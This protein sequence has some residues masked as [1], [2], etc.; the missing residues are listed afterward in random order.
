MDTRCA[1]TH[2]NPTHIICP[3]HSIQPISYALRIL[4]ITISVQR[5]A[6]DGSVEVLAFLLD[7]YPESASI[8]AADGW[9]NLLHLAIAD[10]TNESLAKT[11]LLCSR[12]PAMMYGRD[13]KGLTPLLKVLCLTGNPNPTLTLI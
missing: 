10:D 4:R 6:R 11:R 13:D 12:Y 1:P 8:I 2:F 7:A 3:N 9:F 5:A